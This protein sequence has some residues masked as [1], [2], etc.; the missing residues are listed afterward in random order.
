V[1]IESI[2]TGILFASHEDPTQAGIIPGLLGLDGILVKYVQDNPV[3]LD[4]NITKKF[5][6]DEI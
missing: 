1:D 4:L 5:V 2:V 3:K 6:N